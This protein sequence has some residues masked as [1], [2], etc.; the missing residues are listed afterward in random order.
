MK[1]SAVVQRDWGATKCFR[2]H[3]V[4]QLLHDLHLLPKVVLAAS[5]FHRAAY[6]PFARMCNLASFRISL[7]L[8]REALHRC[9]RTTP[10]VV[11]ASVNP[12]IGLPTPRTDSQEE[13]SPRRLDIAVWT[14][15]RPMLTIPL[16]EAR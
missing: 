1:P 5:P 6:T 11:G 9:V 4:D 13:V 12:F 14:V 10:L 7:H 15:Q 8:H 2:T 3:E 16:H